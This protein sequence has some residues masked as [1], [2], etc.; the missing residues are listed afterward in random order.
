MIFLNLKAIEEHP[1]PRCLAT[2]NCDLL[3]HLEPL[4]R[5]NSEDYRTK[6]SFIKTIFHR[7]IFYRHRTESLIKR[8]IALQS[9]LSDRIASQRAIVL[10][11]SSTGQDRFTESDRT[12]TYSTI[13]QS[14]R[15]EDG[16]A[17]KSSFHHRKILM[18]GQALE[19]HENPIMLTC[20]FF[21]Q[22]TGNP[23]TSMKHPYLVSWDEK[24]MDVLVVVRRSVIYVTQT[25]PLNWALTIT[26]AIVH[27]CCRSDTCRLL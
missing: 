3:H 1:W 18:I 21:V 8:A 2:S 5:T 23:K 10:Q 7:K 14:R 13:E 27:S 24:K 6:S 17:P 9:L 15:P 16:G 22:T 4:L 26:S 19:F 20:C 11:Q 12:P 25:W